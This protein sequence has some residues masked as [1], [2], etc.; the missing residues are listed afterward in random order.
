[1]K[2]LGTKIAYKLYLRV[3]RNLILLLAGAGMEFLCGGNGFCIGKPSYIPFFKADTLIAKK[4]TTKTDT[5]AL[6]KKKS[7]SDELKSQ[8]DYTATDSMV[9]N[10]ENKKVFL[11]GNADVK[12]GKTELTSA[13]ID[14]AMAQ[15]VCFAKGMP[16]S[17]G[18][19]AG[20]PV[21]KD[22]SDEFDA[23]TLSYNFKTKKA[24][25]KDVV[26]KQ[27]E[28][29]LHGAITKKQADGVIDVK[30]GKYTTCD[31]EHPHFYLALTKAMVI[32][33]DKIIAGPAYLVLEDV[34]LPIFIPFGF[35][36]NHKGATS[37]ILMPT[38]GEE[39]SR[40]F[41][42]RGGGYY[43]AINDYMDLAI[44]GDIYTRGTWGLSV[45]SKYAKRYNYGGNFNVSF[46]QNINGVKGEAEYS[47]SKD[48]AITWS[49]RKD[50]KANPYQTF[51]ASVNFSTTSYDRDHTYNVNNYLTNTKTSSVAFSKIWPN[52][53][54]SLTASLN[55][56]QNSINKSINLTLPD[57]SLNMT[58]I[59]PFRKKNSSGGRWWEDIRLSYSS[60]L[61]N[62]IAT[63]DSL[64][65]TNQVFKH[66]QNGYQQSIPLSTS[67][68]VMKFI[69]ITP[70]VSYNGVLYT[71]YVHK[72][73]SDTLYDAVNKKYYGG[74]KTDTIN[75][76]RYAH[77]YLPSISTS[78]SQKIYGLIQFKNSKIQAIRH[79]MTP[80]ASFS[81]TPD[82]S[83][84][85]PNYYKPYK[86]DSAGHI[87][88]YSIFENGIYGT[89]SMRGRSGNVNLSLR[90]TLEMKVK[91]HTDTADVVKKV[92]LLEYFDFGTNYN[93]FADS[94]KWSTISINGGTRLFNQ[95][96]DLRFNGTLDP[97]TLVRT[98]ENTGVRV[99][100]F[101]FI[102]HGRLGRLTNA[103]ISLGMSFQSQDKT[104][105][106]G[107]G[108][109][110][111][112]NPQDREGAQAGPPNRKAAKNASAGDYDYFSIPWSFS[113][114]YELSYYKP[115]YK[116]TFT[117]TFR[118]NGN[119]SLTPKWKVGFS[120]G[121]DFEQK[122]MSMT[123][124]NISRDLHCWELT[125]N[126]VPF[127][128]YRFYEFTIN[129]KSSML[130]DLKYNKRQSWQDNNYY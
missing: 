70:N 124:F 58:S 41:Y 9:I 7:S 102:D 104:S 5:S 126:F 127:G 123:N 94:M 15:G 84:I 120:S 122:K 44:T 39:S 73:W 67:I 62:R 13:Y 30:N 105:T 24:L 93:I 125:A 43:F 92:Q 33:N 25:I 63:T 119:F 130:H 28:G 23:K 91:Q 107:S 76:L 100:R 4:D 69:T 31:A 74:V 16:D 47:K 71:N 17:T 72:Y 108:S 18:Q 20:K 49:H 42:L 101:E 40:G 87:G 48:I 38:Y 79:V 98:G 35:F 82:M 57:M 121:Y 60:S 6:K 27:D 112:S 2:I 22:G 110:A 11:Y 10:M 21:F 95:K 51:S 68:K 56:S 36:P 66:M 32:P 12:Y 116:S 81:F 118:C 26:S 52:S 88:Y 115:Y 55:H 64:L 19:D 53:P 89:P 3:S 29:F 109:G 77:S 103:N 8:I 86:T 129:V 114:D 50:S 75:F 99:N 54:F 85:S 37:G 46:Y 106:S 65:F 97:Y 80:T 34:P 61:Q 1:M 45:A 78:L 90:N 111:D 128:E 59:Y 96:L 117:Q 83:K 113:F 14:Y